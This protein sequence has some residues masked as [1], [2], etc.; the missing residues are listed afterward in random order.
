MI[1]TELYESGE[2]G[3]KIKPN[4]QVASTRRHGQIINV[5]NPRL[6]TYNRYKTPIATVRTRHSKRLAPVG[7]EAHNFN[8]PPRLRENKLQLIR[9]MP[10]NGNLPRVVQVLGQAINPAWSVVDLMRTSKVGALIQKIDTL[11]PNIFMNFMALKNGGL[12]TGENTRGVG[13]AAGRAS[14]E[15]GGVGAVGNSAGGMQ[16]ESGLLNRLDQLNQGLNSLSQSVNNNN[17]SNAQL[18]QEMIRSNMAMENNL[19]QLNTTLDNNLASGLNSMSSILNGGNQNMQLQLQN[20]SQMTQEMVQAANE[21]K[22]LV[23]NISGQY[24][25][26]SLENLINAAANMIRDGMAANWRSQEGLYEIMREKWQELV[27]Q[28]TLTQQNMANRMVE[29][30]DFMQNSL[31]ETQSNMQNMLLANQNN[32]QNNFQQLGN[33]QRLI[34]ERQQNL[35]ENQNVLRAGQNQIG[36]KLIQNE[37][38][39]RE[40]AQIMMNNI[41]ALPKQ[42]ADSLSRNERLQVA[43]ANAPPLTASQAMKII[44]KAIPYY[45][46]PQ[47][48]FYFYQMIAQAFNQ[49]NW[50]LNVNNLNLMLKYISDNNFW[51]FMTN[52]YTD[53]I[54]NNAGP[55]T[56]GYRHTLTN[57]APAQLLK[58]GNLEESTPESDIDLFM[59]FIG[60]FAGMENPIYVAPGSADQQLIQSNFPNAVTK[61]IMSTASDMEIM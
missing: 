9:N 53:K 22:N 47:E 19:A 26:K 33:N 46:H 1:I 8:V 54:L 28:F 14:R 50:P 57:E 4:G 59:S 52:A 55:T 56:E 48:L 15:G 20:N 60:Q 34:Y 39:N 18:N 7:P 45:V 23:T 41:Q 61:A 12:V 36:T 30:R 3:K 49:N 51:A 43:A 10:K 42:I 2:S 31:V 6:S 17:N 40:I 58:T 37:Q 5:P 25:Q 29:D 24:D 32:L 11:L 35:I 38:Q 27:E 16:V 44:S 21:L 13:R